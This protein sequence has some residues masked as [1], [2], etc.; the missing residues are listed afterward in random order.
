MERNWSICKRRRWSWLCSIDCIYDGQRS[1][2]RPLVVFY[3]VWP[4]HRGLR[5]SLSRWHAIHRDRFAPWDR[6]SC[7][8]GRCKRRIVRNR[9]S[10]TTIHTPRSVL[11]NK[12]LEVQQGEES[13]SMDKQVQEDIASKAAGCDTGETK[14]RRSNSIMLGCIHTSVSNYLF[15]FISCVKPLIY[16]LLDYS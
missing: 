13:K 14:A 8:V 10:R 12:S 6:I 2:E 1:S 5:S 4:E 7:G 11:T 3:G 16:P 9:C 15:S